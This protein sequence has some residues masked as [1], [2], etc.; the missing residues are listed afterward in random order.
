LAAD[1]ADAADFEPATAG[2]F[3]VWMRGEGERVPRLEGGER[4]AHL[5]E[6]A[7]AV[8]ELV[9]G[10]GREL[11]EGFAEAVGNE[12]GVVAEAAVAF[13]FVGDDAFDGTAGGGEEFAIEGEDHDAAEA[14]GAFFAA[15]VFGGEFGEEFLAVLGVGG[16]FAGVAG[17]EDAG[18]AV[19]GVDFEAGVVGEDEGAGREGF[20]GG[21]GFDGGVGFEGIAV[22][23]GRGDFGVGGEVG[24][25]VDE[26]VEDGGDLIGFVGVLG[27]D[28]EGGHGNCLNRREQR[29]LR[30]LNH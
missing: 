3:F 25:I 20:I 30:I 2:S 22:F 5:L 28:D 23:D 12:D 19:E 11:A 1:A 24:D 10:F 26:I 4:G 13:F 7:G 9:F 29:E 14:A 18:G 27:G 21:E 17:G 6:G 16:I 8:A 15:D